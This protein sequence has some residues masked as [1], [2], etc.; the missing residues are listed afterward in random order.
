MIWKN[1]D[2]L[3]EIFEN[4][5]DSSEAIRGHALIILA[6]DVRLRKRVTLTA[7]E[8]NSQIMKLIMS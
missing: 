6:R 7:V 5:K 3:A 4:L 1:V 8:S 2:D